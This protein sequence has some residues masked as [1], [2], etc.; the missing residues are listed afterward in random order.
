MQPSAIFYSLTTD[1]P[2]S[3]PIGQLAFSFS[4]GKL[5]IGDD[6]NNPITLVDTITTNDA[7]T[8]TFDPLDLTHSPNAAALVSEFSGK[9]DLGL[10]S[11]DLTIQDSGNPELLVDAQSVADYVQLKLATIDLSSINTSIA[12]VESDI[13]NLQT[14]ITTVTTNDANTNV[15]LDFVDNELININLTLS[16]IQT[17]ITSL[18]DLHDPSTPSTSDVDKATL[19]ISTGLDSNLDYIADAGSNYLSGATNLFNA[20]ILLDSKISYLENVV[21]TNTS[22]ITSINTA[23]SNLQNSL[24]TNDTD[25]TALEVRVTSIEGTL[26][27]LNSFDGSALQLN[28]DTVQLNLN[29]FIT[30]SVAEID[31]LK[32]D[33]AALQALDHVTT[34]LLNSE[35]ATVNTTITALT[36][37][38]NGLTTDLSSLNFTV[39]GQAS[40]ILN[41]NAVVNT[42]AIDLSNLTTAVNNLD[43]TSDSTRLDAIDVQLV[44]ITTDLANL[45]IEHDIENT[46]VN[47]AIT[48][49]EFDLNALTTTVGNNSSDLL[50]LN[51]DVLDVV[52]DLAAL[53]SQV[54]SNVIAISTNSTDIVN[55]ITSNTALQNSINTNET[56]IQSNSILATQN[57]SD[58]VNLLAEI[59]TVNASIANNVSLINAVQGDANNALTTTATNANNIFNHTNDILTLT[60]TLATHTVDYNTLQTDYTNLLNTVTAL[61]LQVNTN[62]DDIDALEN[63]GNTNPGTSIPQQ[64][65]DNVSDISSLQFTDVSLQNQ[66]DAISS[67]IVTSVNVSILQN[68][69]DIIALNSDVNNINIA[70]VNV[71]NDIST[72]NSTLLNVSANTTAVAALNT[73]ISS[74]DFRLTTAETDVLDLDTRLTTAEISLANLQA[75]SNNA[76]SDILILQSSTNA[77]QL[78]ISTAQTDILSVQSDIVGIN[79]DILNNNSHITAIEN[80]LTLLNNEIVSNDT[81]ISDL[82]TRVVTEEAATTDH[83]TRIATIETGLSDHLDIL[84][85][86]SDIGSL[87]TASGLHTTQ[88]SILDGKV[89]VNENAIL[90]ITTDIQST[91]NDT[92]INA[93]SISGLQA[94]LTILESAVLALDPNNTNQ[95]V[96]II[97]NSQQIASLVTQQSVNVGNIN[98]N[99]QSIANILT[100]LIDI[101][102]LVNNN[103]NAVSTITTTIGT[104]NLRLDSIDISLAA[105]NPAAINASI[106][107]TEALV[108]DLNTA[109]SALDFK[110]DNIENTVNDNIIRLAIL[111]TSTT[112]FQTNLSAL[113]TDIS[114]QSTLIS[115]LTVNVNDLLFTVA[116][117]QTETADLP[118]IRTDAA[119]TRFDLDTIIVTANTNKNDVIIVNNNLVSIGNQISTLQSDVINIP[120][121]QANVAT[122]STRVTSLENTDITYQSDINNLL[123]QQT[124]LNT[125][126]GNLSTSF[127]DLMTNTASQIAVIDQTIINLDLAGIDTNFDAI[128]AMLGNEHNQGQ[129]SAYDP[130][131]YNENQFARYINIATNALEADNILDDNLSRVEDAFN[132]YTSDTDL[133]ITTLLTDIGVLQTSSLNNLPTL[134]DQLAFQLS[135]DANYEYDNTLV[136]FANYTLNSQTIALAIKDLDWALTNLVDVEIDRIDTTLLSLQGQIDLLSVGNTTP[137]DLTNI[138]LALTESVGLV[139]DTN[140]GQFNPEFNQF[141]RYVDDETTDIVTA[142]EALDVAI[143][144]IENDA[145]FKSLDNVMSGTIEYQSSPDLAVTEST[146]PNQLVTAKTVKDYVDNSSIGNAQSQIDVVEANAGLDTDGTYIAD[147][148][149]NYIA[150]ATTIHNATQILDNALLQLSQIVSNIQNNQITNINSQI[151]SVI[152]DLSNITNTQ[153]NTITGIGEFINPDGTFDTIDD[154]LITSNYMSTANSITEALLLLDN[155]LASGGGS[156][157]MQRYE[158]ALPSLVWTITHGFNTT[159]IDTTLRDENNDLMYA[160]VDIIDANTIRVN[161]TEA[162][163]GELILRY[164]LNGI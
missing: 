71:N 155:S 27:T 139:L 145:V 111:E 52:T 67:T 84:T 162:Q 125:T 109:V 133:I 51:T 9:L 119:Q 64:I 142:I 101:D 95:D 78:D 96:S 132:T 74:I 30:Q 36:A 156:G 114:S 35:I 128:L 115:G 130:W 57:Q 93:T 40:D 21:S 45:Q 32:V 92:V 85:N 106:I 26:T 31:I 56:D 65:A 164:T 152:S 62:V 121:L 77:I 59:A 60:N 22:D 127:N 33:V 90:S 73:T 19:I 112:S 136:N 81:D 87:I 117:L 66:I 161:F 75:A 28:I 118:T 129:T 151:T 120:P 70:L 68:Q 148:A 46:A 23:V 134:I 140:T 113:S 58:I 44:T 163:S 80:S 143:S 43:L 39:T 2:P 123:N 100:T 144:D 14:S 16:A 138:N 5:F 3:L 11:F 8:S 34:T 83:E 69:N 154:D 116:S 105:I 63:A 103:V 137:L 157:G 10:V 79:S 97:D 29:T 41:T 107:T 126:I 110:I 42:L 108:N 1:T 131:T 38:V 12:S 158:F 48:S 76:I 86:A 160:P 153:N 50:T 147:G 49:V 135:L 159:L 6:N 47:G 55:L 20:D 122:L 37:T 91:V 89:A 94:G 4:S 99:S 25:D 24:N 104:I 53:Q 61:N 17:T 82:Q 88:L 146:K 98:A 7:V 54:N 13:V 124:T 72:I 150:P 18:S 149:A 102:T 141:G 15:R